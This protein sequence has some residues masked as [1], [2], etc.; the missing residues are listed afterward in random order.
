MPAT[1]DPSVVTNPFA[2]LGQV[3]LANAQMEA[4]RKERERIRRDQERARK[5]ASASALGSSLGSILAGGAALA[6]GGPAGMAF[7]GP[8]MAAGSAIGG[9]LIGGGDAPPVS[10]GQAMQI[11]LGAFQASQ[12]LK[13]QEA[14]AAQTAS[15]REIL[16]GLA[17]TTRAPTFTGP[18]MFG[19]GGGAPG[20]AGGTQPGQL[21]QVGQ[22]L[23]GSPD[24]RTAGNMLSIQQAIQ[25]KPPEM[26]IVGSAATGFNRVP[27][28]GPPEQVVAPKAAALPKPPKFN[29]ALNDAI[30]VATRNPANINQSIDDIIDIEAEKLGVSRNLHDP[31]IAAAFVTRQANYNRV[32]QEEIDTA[33]ED[34]FVTDVNEVYTRDNL[35]SKV[36]ISNIRSLLADF[37]NDI[38][39]NQKKWA[40]GLIADIVKS[41]A[42]AL[43][44]AKQASAKTKLPDRK[45]YQLGDEII[46][47]I[48]GGVTY[49]SQ[50]ADGKTISIPIPLDRAKPL[51][52]QKRGDLISRRELQEAAKA[53]YDAYQSASQQRGG[54]GSGQFAGN[55]G[56]IGALS[57]PQPGDTKLQAAARGGTGFVSWL[58]TVASATVGQAFSGELDPVNQRN[59]QV[60]RNFRNGFIKRVKSSGRI[61]KDER[62]DILKIVAD[63]DKILVDPDTSANNF[64]IIEDGV[65]R[66][67]LDTLAELGTG[68]FSPQ[69]GRELRKKANEYKS[70]LDYMRQ[71]ID[72]KENRGSDSFSPDPGK[73]R[74]VDGTTYIKNGRP[75]VWHPKGWLKPDKVTF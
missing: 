43:K 1:F 62:A 45:Y 14:A 37:G 21:S 2:Q 68:N 7:L 48:D 12:T 18:E 52:D 67:Y 50:N 31:K 26:Q 71:P 4:Q 58:K 32:Q 10:P 20:T 6:F 47:S 59:R 64:K 36:K 54:A 39:P 55:I 63:P 8:A 65:E 38:K 51:T 33:A 56:A 23:A 40:A 15:E 49:L 13:A 75:W 73:G 41:D 72:I 70:L 16:G 9:P 28:Q 19:A 60:L 74:R 3:R 11:G 53:E 24:L 25:P 29:K 22:L 42:D 35:A 17:E 44:A 69:E 57:Q 30:R 61:L 27:V 5:R 66:G 46:E 34:N